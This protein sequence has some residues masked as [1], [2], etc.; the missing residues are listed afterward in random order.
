MTQRAEY[1]LGNPPN[2]LHPH[3]SKIQPVGNPFTRGESVLIQGLQI[4]LT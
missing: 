2:R 4:G 3:D 1:G